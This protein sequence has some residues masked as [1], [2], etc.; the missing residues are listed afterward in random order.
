MQFGLLQLGSQLGAPAIVV[1]TILLVMGL[2]AL[3]AFFER[4]VWLRRSR[5]DSAAFAGEAE[6]LLDGGRFDDVVKVSER[7]PHAQLARIV[8]EGLRTHE[9]ARATPDVSGLSPV[10]RTQRH[11]ERYMEAVATDL[12]RGLSVLSS[13]GSTAPF[14]GLLGTVL[15]IISAFQGIAETGSGGLSA[16]SAGISEALIETALGLVVAIPA[17]LGFNYLATTISREEQRL[18]HASGE[19]LDRIE[20]RAE[21]EGKFGTRDPKSQG[22]TKSV[23]S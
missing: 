15:G 18:Q 19:L 12:R 20:G 22:S 11:M 13:V 23:K 6:P 8:R 3:S 21:L 10:D 9:H 14:V 16:V 17:V 1:A 2:V 7:F 4:L 5:R